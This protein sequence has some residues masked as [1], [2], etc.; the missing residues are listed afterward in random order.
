V[1]VRFTK[2]ARRSLAHKRS[3]KLTI[4]IKAGATRSVNVTLRRA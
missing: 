4:R 2:Q 3:V 1:R